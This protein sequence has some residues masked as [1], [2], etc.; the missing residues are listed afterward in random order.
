[1]A[2]STPEVVYVTE[3]CVVESMHTRATPTRTRCTD[4]TLSCYDEHNAQLLARR[5]A[6]MERYI[7]DVRSKCAVMEYE[8]SAYKLLPPYRRG[9]TISLARMRL[10]A[11]VSN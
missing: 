3:R 4:G 10:T 9:Q 6:E 8:K 5:L 2:A 11:G 7:S 1:M